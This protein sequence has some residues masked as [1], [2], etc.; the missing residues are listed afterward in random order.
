MDRERFDVRVV[1]WNAEGERRQGLEAND[2]P[3]TCAHGDFDRLS[4]LLQGVDL[5]H[6]FRHGGAE[7]LPVQACKRAGVSIL[8]DENIFGAVD[9]SADETLFA[10]H[11][12]ISQMCLLRYRTLVGDQPGFADRHRVSYL[13]VDAATLRSLAQERRAAKAALGFDPDRPVVGRLG[14]PADLKW[15][16]MLIDMV[17]H[18]SGLVP[19]VQLLYVGMTLAKQRRAGRL[20]LLERI[21]AY[22]TTADEER[23]ALFYSACDVVVNASAIGESQGVALAEA[24]ALGVPVVT[25]STPWTDNAQVE[26]VDNGVN[27]WIANH[28]RPFAE[29]VADLLMNDERR[30]AFGAAAAAKVA[31]LFDPSR[32]TRQLERLYLHHLGHSRASL[33]WAPGDDALARFEHD[34][35]ARVTSEFR[36]LTRRERLEAEIERGNDRARRLRSS[37]AMLSA[38]L[39]ATRRTPFA[40]RNRRRRVP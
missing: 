39:V 29:A 19:D 33:D 6:L 25:C 37:A 7:P 24:M 11:L 36:P 4:S 17:P 22:P 9:H 1:T 15:R 32:L 3:V 20:G 40:G 14:R 28:P 10:C 26:V 5:A 35:A 16:D 31:R 34:Y 13:P 12:F 8:I 21:R 30:V 2:I 18:L 27:G 23:L 38:S